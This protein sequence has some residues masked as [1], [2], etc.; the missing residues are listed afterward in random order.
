ML[1]S[2]LI[3]S[4]AEL[5]AMPS[6]DIILKNFVDEFVLLDHS[7]TLE[8][9]ACNVYGKHRTASAANISHLYLLRL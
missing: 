2:R 4:R 6:F 8:A 1:K 7:Q 5:Q 9:L 3:A